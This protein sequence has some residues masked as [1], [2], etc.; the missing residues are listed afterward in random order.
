ML[1]ANYHTHTELCGHA[2]GSVKD[3]VEEAIKLGF[4]EL[5]MSDH[6]HTPEYFMSK[7]DYKRHGLERI[8]T[9]EEF[10]NIY[11]LQVLK[12]KERKDIKVFLGLETEY[13]PEFHEH[14]VN[15]RK[16]LD[17]LILGLHFFNYGGKNYSTYFDMDKNSLEMYTEIAIKAMA[18]GIYSIFAHPD[19]FMYSYQSE[20]GE[21]VFDE[22]CR[23]CSQ[24]IID[25]AIKNDVYLEVNANGIQNTYRDFPA[26]TNYL[27]PREEFWELARETNVKIIIGADAHKPEAL[28][29]EIVRDAIAFA[30]RLRLNICD[31]AKLKEY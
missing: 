6:A 30:E 1:K 12:E 11:V 9:D 19:L 17:Y 27:Y 10:E 14:F 13:Y 20:K 26:Y 24:R 2:V 16:K 21:R 31:F 22:H 3:Y 28:G 5:G 29:N 4:V 15:L 25:A 7:D 8:M 23:E 18:T